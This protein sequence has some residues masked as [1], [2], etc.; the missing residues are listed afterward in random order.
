M[1][2]SRRDKAIF[3]TLLAS[4]IIIFLL[5]ISDILFPFIVGALVAY[6]LDPVADKLEDSGM[7][8]TYA[9]SAIIVMFSLVMIMVCLMVFPVLY[10]QLLDLYSNIPNIISSLQ[11]KFNSVFGEVYQKIQNI[12]NGEDASEMGSK[13][14]DASKII[15]KFITDFLTSVIESGI[16]MLNLLSLIFIS[17]IVAFYMLRDYD[18]IIAKIDGWL[19]LDHADTIREQLSLIDTTL[20]GFVRGAINV[21]ILQGIFYAICLSIAGLQ[22]G[23]LIGFATGILSFIPYVG[24]LIGMSTGLAVAFFQFGLADGGMTSILIV[25]S[26]FIVG[27]V[28]EGN[29]LTPKLVGDKVGLH[30]LWIMFG[31]LAGGSLFGFT[32]VLIAIP[33]SAT[34]GVISRFLLGEYL[35]SSY[36]SGSAK[37]FVDKVGKSENEKDAGNKDVSK[38]GASK[39][40]AS[41][42]AGNQNKTGKEVKAAAVKTKTAKK[43][44]TKK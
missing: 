3:W 28:L 18:K 22:Y 20:S 39:V 2:I 33:V 30:A 24:M 21:C 9:T 19:P 35:K 14:A 17:P 12:A 15:L 23:L 5:V 10:D 43:T 13:A 6:F 16:A 42:N 37:L 4:S 11:G 41:K 1:K 36:Y 8:R 40:G 27:Q 7:S 29:F 44:K 31:L 34:L 32:G 25:L 38:K 26:I